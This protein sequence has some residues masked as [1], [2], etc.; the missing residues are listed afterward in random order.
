M[1][2]TIQRRRKLVQRAPTN[3]PTLRMRVSVA[4][5]SSLIVHP[6]FDV[7]TFRNDIALVR[8]ATPLDLE[9]AH[10]NLETIC[11]PDPRMDFRRA[12]CMAT[13][14][15]ETSFPL[16]DKVLEVAS[17]TVS[18]IQ[19]PFQAQQATRAAA[20]GDEDAGAGIVGTLTMARGK[21][22]RDV[23]LWTRLTDQTATLDDDVPMTRCERPPLGLGEAAVAADFPLASLMTV[24]RSRNPPGNESESEKNVVSG[25]RHSELLM[26]VMLPVW[27]HQDCYKAY[28]KYNKITDKMF[29][30]G[31]KAG[32]K[33]SCSGDSGGPL[34][35]TFDEDVWY[36]GGVVS[37]SVY[38]ALPN[39]PTVFT[40]VVSYLPYMASVMKRNARN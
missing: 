5:A 26:E 17:P 25:G 10:S 19:A 8:L 23:E 20:T 30:A 2:F 35:C 15:G 38:C 34:Q 9:G 33:S 40:K 6:H 14:W 36:L 22:G 16:A 13:G 4:T 3:C 21:C 18:N 37:H 24:P 11:L 39:M 32:K 28:V 27:D 12:R 31:Y 7:R 29:C 1:V